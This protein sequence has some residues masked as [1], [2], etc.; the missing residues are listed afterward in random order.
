MPQSVL[1]IGEHPDRIDFSAPGVPPGM[2][3]QKVTEGL[4]GSRE[5]LK[6]LGHEATILLTRDAATI[7]ALVSGSPKGNPLRCDCH[8]RGPPNSASD[9][10]AVRTADQCAA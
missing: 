4:R 2:S 10:R 6:G 8:R 5:R 1:I 9:G 7:D 3:A